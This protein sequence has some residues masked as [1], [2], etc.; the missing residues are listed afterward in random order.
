V[1][2]AN[3]VSDNTTLSQMISM[4]EKIVITYKIKG[5]NYNTNST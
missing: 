1:K 5:Y 3:S 4:L 2:I